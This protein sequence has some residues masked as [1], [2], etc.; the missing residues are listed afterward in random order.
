MKTFAVYFK[1]SRQIGP[2]D[3]AA[4]NE[5]KQFDETTTLKEISDWAISEN[6]SVQMPQLSVNELNQIVTN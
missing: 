1:N 6:K 5:M 4:F 3:W 2:D